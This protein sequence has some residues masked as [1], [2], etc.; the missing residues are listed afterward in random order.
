M[1]PGEDGH[2]VALIPAHTQMKTRISAP[3]SLHCCSHE[4]HNR[5]K[6][7]ISKYTEN[8]FNILVLS[9][10]LISLW[11]RGRATSR[12]VSACYIALFTSQF[13]V[14]RISFLEINNCLLAKTN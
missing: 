9:L 6:K 1:P 10:A 7:E 14:I 2:K 8:A 11:G 3:G 4:V 12:E 13:K 5:N